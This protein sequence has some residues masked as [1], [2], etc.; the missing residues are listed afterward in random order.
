MMRADPYR[1]Y[2]F[3]VEVDATEQG[4]FQSVGGLARES[5][6]ETFREGGV[7]TFEHQLVT[8]TTY[9][10]LVLKRGLVDRDLWEWHERVIL[11]DVER[12]TISIVLVGEGGNEAW[13]WVVQ[14]A[15]PSKWTLGELDAVG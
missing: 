15:F 8:L 3:R 4:G 2:R 6:I 5:N 11:G 1:A 14:S 7:N 12:K 10:T 9:P 13:R